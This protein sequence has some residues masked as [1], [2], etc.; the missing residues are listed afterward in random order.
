MSYVL[1][2]PMERP[3]GWNFE[4]YFLYADYDIEELLE[5][6]DSELEVTREE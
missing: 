4:A 3:K 1:A 6:S 2:P 5:L